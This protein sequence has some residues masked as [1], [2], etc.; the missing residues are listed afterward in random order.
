[1]FVKFEAQNKINEKKNKYKGLDCTN[2]RYRLKRG[3]KE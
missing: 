2:K 1:M 3:L